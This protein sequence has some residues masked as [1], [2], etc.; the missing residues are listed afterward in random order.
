MVLTVTQVQ[1]LIAQGWCLIP[2]LQLG[3]TEF[4]AP[5]MK[6]INLWC[7]DTQMPALYRGRIRR[8][9]RDFGNDAFCGDIRHDPAFVDIVEKSDIRRVVD[10]IIG[11]TD[12]IEPQI[13]L[14]FSDTETS[15]DRLR[16]HIDGFT[17]PTSINS[18]TALVG[19]YLSDVPT[20]N[21]GNF[22][23]WPGSHRVMAEYFSRPSTI[24][25]I[26]KHRRAE[27]EAAMNEIDYGAHVQVTAQ[28]GDTIVCH[29]LLRHGTAQNASEQTRSMIFVRFRSL[30]H[31]SGDCLT[32]QDLW[33]GWNHERLFA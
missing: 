31:K 1:S 30:R 33:N 5:A 23:V 17:D 6:R 24:D 18:F 10:F 14:K 19:I 8:R 22:T 15:W 28:L 4:V 9:L 29:Y 21:M 2:A 25:L 26:M 3:T 13:A 11:P 32:F 27:L 16:S 20:H 12:A 7:A